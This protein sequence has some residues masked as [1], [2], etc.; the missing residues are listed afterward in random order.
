M[1]DGT[2]GVP[3]PIDRSLMDL[4]VRPCDDFWSYANGG[5]LRST[6]IPADESGRGGFLELRDRNLDVL[7]ELLVAAAAA[8]A[9][10]GS[11][12]QLAGDLFASGIDE[13]GS[14]A[15]DLAALRPDLDGI[16]AVRS[17]ADLPAL[18]GRLQ[19][20]GIH[21]GLST[22]VRPSAFTSDRNLLHLG[23]GGLGMPDRE[24]YLSDDP[25]TRETRAAYR[26]VVA[27]LLALCG[28]D[29]ASAAEQADS[30]M[31][32]ETALAEASMPRVDLRDPY[33][34]NH[35]LDRAALSVLTPGFD[36]AAFLGGLGARG[37]ADVNV[38]QPVFLEA[39]ARL[40]SE[41]SLDE[42]RIYLRWRVIRQA[43]PFLM[44]ACEAAHFSFY[45]TAL[46][47][48]LE[49]RP[50]WKRVIAV[51]D[52]L[53][54]DA[55]GRLY[56]ERAFPAA[57][58]AAVLDLVGDLR[59]A[60][61]ERIAALPWMSA[62]TKRAA[63]AKLD[64]FTVKMG[65][66]DRWRAND[67]LSIDRGSYLANVVRVWRHEIGRDLGKLAAPVDRS[68]WRMS[69]PTVNAYYSPTGNEIVFPAGILQPPFFY[70]GGDAAA[71]YGA[72]GMVIGHEMTHGFDDSGSQ[73]DAGGNLRNWWQAS[74]REAYESRTDLVVRQYD[75]YE[76][77]QGVRVNGK[78]CLGENIADLGG[79][80]IAYA[81]FERWLASHG[82][83]APIDG[84]TARQRFFLG[85]AQAWRSVMRDEALRVR[86]ATD[87]HSPARFRVMGPLSNL[88]E[89]FEA[90]G[91]KGGAMARPAA[92]RPTIW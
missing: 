24:Y 75:E 52:E 63:Q 88:P 46:Q 34:V 56:V 66:P 26:G 59:S 19:A 31:S 10:R 11:A 9:P 77:L 72:I 50:R 16:E 57:A 7:H 41:R 18:L 79:L 4:S 80:R 81:A 55:V 49:Q 89:F 47:G 3:R 44:P 15:A 60:L 38:R 70:P 23:Q 8:A 22:G 39:L 20:S 53:V 40:T 2:S 12:T 48:Q 5:W 35:E 91:D 87:P 30:V 74:D 67:G 71:N 78:L 90:F 76:P 82:E 51:V 13:A 54:P 36:W 6:T 85:Y 58:K 73:Y 14:A 64:A 27:T 61:G 43:A 1:T 45:G 32:F 65:Y 29:A 28:V 86:L 42:W 84:F 37:V 92:L 69:A 68:E 33:K 62:V 25:R 17:G 83:P 21:A